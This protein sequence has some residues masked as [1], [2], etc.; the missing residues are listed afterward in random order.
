MK[1]RTCI[2]INF[3]GDARVARGG[4]TSPFLLEDLPVPSP[5]QTPNFGI[6]PWLEAGVCLGLRKVP[7]PELLLA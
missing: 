2:S 3:P 6:L 7:A 4:L 1:P 5:G